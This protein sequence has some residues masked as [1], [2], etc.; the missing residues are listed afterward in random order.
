M[1]TT[2]ITEAKDAKLLEETMVEV[3][4]RKDKLNIVVEVLK[5]ARIEEEA[6]CFASM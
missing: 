5:K 6:S 4:P 2:V 3:I 1:T